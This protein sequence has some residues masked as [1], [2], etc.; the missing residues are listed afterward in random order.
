MPYV[1]VPKDMSK[2]K[3]K[4]L[5]GLT[6]RQI[7]CFGIAGLIGVPA[8]LIMRKSLGLGGEI[9]MIAM[10]VLMMPFFFLGMYAKDGLPA[11]KVARNILRSRL[12]PGVRPYRT[13]NLFEWLGKGEKTQSGKNES[14][15][16]RKKAGQAAVRQSEKAGR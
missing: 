9:S 16:R 1:S 6:K 14:E 7:V 10:I 3:V 15:T 2:I 8:Y 12:W 13:E 5:F 11:E 4:V